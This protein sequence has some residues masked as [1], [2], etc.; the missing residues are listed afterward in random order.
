MPYF[1][2]KMATQLQNQ[3]II[4]SSGVEHTTLNKGITNGDL[5][6]EKHFCFD[7]DSENPAQMSDKLPYLPS[8][9]VFGHP[10]EQ[11]MQPPLSFSY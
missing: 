11:K 4:H 6:K 9:S 2:Y 7:S 1:R 3:C 8:D 5:D 10:L